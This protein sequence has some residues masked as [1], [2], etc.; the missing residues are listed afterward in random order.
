MYRIVKFCGVMA[1]SMS[2]AGCVPT[3][4]VPSVSEQVAAAEAAGY[5]PGGTFAIPGIPAN[6][7]QCQRSAAILADP[8]ST[9]AER[10][11]AKMA[12]DANGC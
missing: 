3:G 2:A 9:P 12:A 5:K 6:Q 11:G 1:V 8:T 7:S 4:M 10:S